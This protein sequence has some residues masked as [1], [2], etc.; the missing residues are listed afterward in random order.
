MNANREPKGTQAGGQFAPSANP[1]STI[2]LGD[3]GDLEQSAPRGSLAQLQDLA[4]ASDGHIVV[5]SVGEGTLSPRPKRE[6]VWDVE[7]NE[8]DGFKHVFV[9]APDESAA[10]RKVIDTENCH[11]RDISEVTKSDKTLGQ[12]RHRE[13][14]PNGE[15]LRKG[16]GHEFV[17]PSMLETIPDVYAQENT[18]LADQTVYAHF[19]SSNGDWYITEMDKSEGLAFGHCDLG[20]GFPEWGYVDIKELESVRHPQFPSIAAVERDLHFTSKKVRELGLERS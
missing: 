13:I 8:L 1:E 4:D 6:P 19:F 14:W 7:V 9:E 15:T 10:V 12:L 2:D 17:T 20:M 3:I 5:I 18:P 16:R 11:P